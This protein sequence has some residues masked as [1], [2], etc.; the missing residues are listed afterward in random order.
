[1]TVPSFDLCGQ[2]RRQG[3]GG[4]RVS[5]RT[6]VSEEGTYA[7]LC[8][9]GRRMH[10]SVLQPQS[11]FQVPAGESRGKMKNREGLCSC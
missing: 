11:G 2:L 7:S 9:P 5:C 10:R 6:F 3:S 8:L 1:M 4:A